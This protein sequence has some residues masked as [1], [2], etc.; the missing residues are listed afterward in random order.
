MRVNVVLHRKR[1]LMSKVFQN[2]YILEMKCVYVSY[3]EKSKWSDTLLGARRGDESKSERV[4]E[5]KRWR[6][7][8]SSRGF[9]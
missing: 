5:S 6:M 7:C 1:K 3:S 4:N 2:V 8:T 9:M